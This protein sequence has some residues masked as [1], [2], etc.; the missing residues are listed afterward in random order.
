[1]SRLTQSP[2][3]AALARHHEAMRVIHMRDLF[4]QDPA[5]AQSFS[6][7]FNDILFDFSKNRITVETLARL[8]DL[9]SE[10]RLN[11]AIGRMFDGRPINATEHRPA[12]HV[13][14]RNRSNRPILVD[15]RDVMPQVNAVLSRM[16]TFTEQVRG[17]DWKGHTG[18]TIT[19]V[20][21]IGIG[22]S[23][24]GPAMA[25]RALGP[26]VKTGMHLHFVSNV[27]ATDLVE[28][29]AQLEPETTLFV[30]AS[31]TFTTEETLTNAHSARDWL[32][33]RLGSEQAV[34]R[35]FV[36]VSTNAEKVRAFGIDENHM[37]EFWDWVGGRYSLWSAI[38]LPL[39]LGIGWDHFEAMLSGAHEMDEHFR[40]EPLDRN[41][42]VLAGL[43][44][45]WY[46]NF[47]G[48]DSQAILPYDQHLEHLPAYLQQLYME[49]NGKRVTLAGDDVDYAT[50]P[51]VW[52]AAGTN[53]QHS[54]YQLIHQGTQVIPADF[55]A[56]IESQHPL[57]KHHEILLANFFAQPEALMRGKTAEQVRAELATR[58]LS[59]EAIAALTPHRIFPGNRPT[60][61]I[62]Y[63]RL[64][65]K[66]LGT[67]LAFYEH[68]VFVQG[69]LWNI[70][71]FD[72]WGVELG[73][74]LARVVEADIACQGDISPHDS[75]TAQL[76][77]RF[78]ARKPSS[79]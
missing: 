15:S 47:F 2:A 1:M 62:L 78:K 75:S 53:G 16:R 32:V 64:D 36:A 68:R 73:K 27:D 26:Y 55:L 33:A 7:L 14:L 60:H 66:T 50:C 71:S 28:T 69:A 74:E 4:E 43:I 59:P 24:L 51:V 49:S 76:I 31:K 25:A 48:F 70:D 3:W 18:K 23:D 46:A 6:Y 8:F 39:A 54:F 34:A 13:A 11:E 52:G 21:N 35:H 57:G 45:L 22:G 63:Q 37:F 56:A 10:C 58:G 42:P 77:E 17:G 29:L 65:A 20:V 30:V 67:L 41:I 79:H 61:S 12:L 19:D 38:G 72:Q 44:A 40:T 9:A 5:R